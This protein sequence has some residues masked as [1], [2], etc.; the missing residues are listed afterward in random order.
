[1]SIYTTKI[2]CIIHRMH[3]PT[4]SNFRMHLHCARHNFNHAF[5][6]PRL[7]AADALCSTLA[8]APA[9][10]SREPQQ[11]SS[12]MRKERASVPALCRR[13]CPSA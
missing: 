10:L 5:P 4:E 7:N 13:W 8:I 6:N 1:M 11:R 3:G 9:S 12:G 2:T